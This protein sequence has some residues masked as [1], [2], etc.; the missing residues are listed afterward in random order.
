MR[1]DPDVILLGKYE[2]KKLRGTIDAS[3]TGHLVISTI[4]ANDCFSVI[5]RLEGLG[6]DKV[7]IEKT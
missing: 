4:H 6:V 3:N 2:I 1:Q 5:E 7:L